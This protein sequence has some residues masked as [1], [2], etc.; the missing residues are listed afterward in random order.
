MG[1]HHD[2][3]HVD[4]EYLVVFFDLHLGKRRDGR[5]S[6]IVDEN[7]EAAVPLADSLN[8]RLYPGFRFKVGSK[9][10]YLIAMGCCFGECRFRASY[11][12]YVS[13]FIGQTSGDGSSD[14]CSGSGYEG[15]FVI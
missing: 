4:G 8:H 1:K 12:Q 14:T 11:D 2:G 3:T 13:T 7:I 15:D 6:G 5:P 9:K 10:G